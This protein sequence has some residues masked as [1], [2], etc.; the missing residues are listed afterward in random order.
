MFV[1]PSKGKSGIQQSNKRK[2]GRKVLNPIF[3]EDR[4]AEVNSNIKFL[5][6]E[7]IRL[8]VSKMVSLVVLT[9]FA[10]LNRSSKEERSFSSTKYP[11]KI[12]YSM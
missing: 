11:K 5:S 1:N 12:D 6:K 10:N 9:L 4:L 7:H 8:G 2:G 3:L